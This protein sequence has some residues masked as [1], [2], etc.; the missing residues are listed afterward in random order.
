MRIPSSL[1]GLER[2]FFVKAFHALGDQVGTLTQS[3]AFEHRH[4][5][6]NAAK[7]SGSQCGEIGRQKEDGCPLMSIFRLCWIGCIVGHVSAGWPLACFAQE[8]LPNAYSPNNSENSDDLQRSWADSGKPFN[9]AKRKLIASGKISIDHAAPAQ[10]LEISPLPSD[11]KLAADVV[12]N[13]CGI[14]LIV[15]ATAGYDGPDC[16]KNTGGD[17]VSGLAASVQADKRVFYGHAIRRLYTQ[18]LKYDDHFQK[19]NFF[20][21]DHQGFEERLLKSGQVGA[22]AEGL[23]VNSH[24]TPLSAGDS[25]VIKTFPVKV[26]K[27]GSTQHLVARSAW[28][29]SHHGKISYA[30]CIYSLHGNINRAAEA[31]TCFMDVSPTSYTSRYVDEYMKV[32]ESL[33][34]SP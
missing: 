17:L 21:F 25:K 9:E 11:W 24:I 5:T 14:S 4:S 31:M 3:T 29:H 30:T 28:S 1:M 18:G 22:N 23:F 10:P 27:I 16:S 13:G 7:E 32:L 33:Q 20:V 8:V 6:G 34:V 12:K 2:P 26:S 15:P 19:V